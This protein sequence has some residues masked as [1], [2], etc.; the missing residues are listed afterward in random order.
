MVFS[1]LTKSSVQKKPVE[2]LTFHVHNLQ[3][4]ILNKLPVLAGF[5]GRYMQT[6]F[7]A[8]TEAAKAELMNLVGKDSIK[9]GHS[10]D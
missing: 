5:R 6:D 7:K 3:L 8:I 4:S 9:Q 10:Q 2:P 1:L